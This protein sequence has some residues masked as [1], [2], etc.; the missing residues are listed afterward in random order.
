MIVRVQKS[1]NVH[2]VVNGGTY[3]RE[4]K[5]NRQISAAEITELSMRRGA[6]SPLVATVDADFDL[7]D[8]Q[9]W[10][11]YRDS[12]RLTRPISE[13]MYHIG[14]ARKDEAGRLRPT[15]AAV[16]LFAE[17]PPGLLDSKC[18]VRIFHYRGEQV[19]HPRETN[20]LALP[21]T[22]GGPVIAQ[23]RGAT[24]AVLNT[25]RSGLQVSPLGFK[26]TQRYP[27]R[28]IQEAITN[29]VIHRDYRLNKDIHVLIFSNR[30][31]V[32]SP[33]VFPGPV[34]LA[35]IGRIGSRPRNRA[36]VDHLREFPQ[37]PNLDAGEGVPMMRQGMSQVNLYP[38]IFV[39]QPQLLEEA[40]IVLLLNQ[41]Q[42][43]TWAQVRD[44][45]QK[46]GTI[47]NAQVRTILKTDDPTL[48]SRELRSWVKLG[49]LVV[50]NPDSAKKNRRYR[51]PEASP[52]A[53]LFAGLLAKEQGE[54]E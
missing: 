49:L 9:I 33:G 48:A 11:D 46:H 12:R 20:L 41:V 39:T 32:K 14:L 15:K 26:I 21:R 53:G 54:R 3:I 37:P 23:I 38:P 52:E 43:S 25:L 5:S 30:I 47:G 28:V 40:V 10:R 22:V 19:E 8:T 4:D 18:S 1:G 44:Y 51:L 16:L 45:L 17:E 6:T 36:L 7:L 13:A 29:A 42:P 34:T 2:S 31:E 50:A 27:D 24:E 35:N